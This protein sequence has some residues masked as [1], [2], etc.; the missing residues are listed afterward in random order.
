MKD[1]NGI[2]CYRATVDDEDTGMV[3]VSLVD[4]PAVEVDFLAFDKQQPLQFNIQDEEQRMVLGVVMRPNYPMYRRDESGWEYFVEY[5]PETIHKMAERFFATMNVNSVDTDHSFELVEGVTLVQAFF[6]NVEKGINPTGFED[7]PDDTLFFQYHITNDEIWEGVKAGTWK[8]FSLAGS[9][10]IV[11]IQMKNNNKSNRT[12]MSKLEK[13]R[14]ALQNI[15]AQFERI[16]TDKALIEYDGEELEVGAAV[17][18]VDEEGN[19]FNLEDGEYTVEDGTVY[20]IAEGKVVE[21]REVEKEPEA[22]AAEA[23][24][25]T[26]EN[27]EEVPQSE[28]EPEA[29][30]RDQRIADL[31]AEVARLE[32]E[33]GALKE[34]IAELENK[35]AANPA[36]EDFENVNKVEKTGNAKTDRLLRI[37]NA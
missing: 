29:D 22:P 30:P 1:I 7:L 17:H 5:T 20:V 6:K 23:P 18:G 32:E 11:P 4:A 3:V 27:A 34:R 33:N 35:P 31:E 24:Q 14:T 21:I 28:E 9:F 15:L 26:V 19:P 16:S 10:N 2:P 37:I 13:L 25:E 12:E 36:S 8:G